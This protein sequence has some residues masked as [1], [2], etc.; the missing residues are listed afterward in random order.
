[1]QLGAITEVE[2]LWVTIM[3]L[4]LL[5]VDVIGEEY[6]E[7]LEV[8][9]LDGGLE[10]VEF[11]DFEVKELDGDRD[12]VEF[13]VLEVVELDGGRDIV[14]FV[15]LEVVELEGDWDVVEFVN[16]E[17]DEKLDVLV[18]EEPRDCYL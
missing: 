16:L 9:G 12:I 17:V 1:L 3:V 18:E 10:V 7:I 14:E 2:E 15:V 4:P 13:D 5:L 8:E 6:E 11:V